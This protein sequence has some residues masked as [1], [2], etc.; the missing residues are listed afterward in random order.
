MAVEFILK[1]LGRVPLDFFELQT[2]WNDRPTGCFSDFDGRVEKGVKFTRQFAND[3]NHSFPLEQLFDT[4]ENELAHKK[5][6]AISLQVPEGW[7]NYI[8]YD[9]LPDGEFAAVTKG[10]SPEIITNVKQQ[11]RNMNGTDILTYDLV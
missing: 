5:Y 2:Q 6:V 7:H 8:V 1:L 3:R 9:P 10:R 4:I 11:V